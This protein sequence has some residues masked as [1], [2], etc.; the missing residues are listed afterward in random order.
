MISIHKRLS[1]FLTLLLL[2]TSSLTAEMTSH[3][4]YTSAW[5]ASGIAEEINTTL[6]SIQEKALADNQFFEI[7]QIS[8]VNFEDAYM[9]YTLS[10]NKGVNTSETK[11]AYVTAW[12]ASGLSKNLQDKIDNLQ[13]LA[14][15]SNESIQILDIYI[16]SGSAYIIY[17]VSK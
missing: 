7:I 10:D 2:A 16:L 13:T 9:V 17:E 3:V 12:T 4:V 5:T 15:Q 1:S 6:A 11:I 14:F 8:I